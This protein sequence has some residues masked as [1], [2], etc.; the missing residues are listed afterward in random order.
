MVRVTL[1]DNIK[2]TLLEKVKLTL[3]QNCKD[4][5]EL[6]EIFHFLLVTAN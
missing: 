4:E 1:V 5:H 2:V 6:T 3:L